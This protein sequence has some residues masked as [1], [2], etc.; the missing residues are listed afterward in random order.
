MR[1]YEAYRT[2][3]C[4]AIGC[5]ESE[6]GSAHLII[7]VCVSLSL[8]WLSFSHLVLLGAKNIEHFFSFHTPTNCS[9]IM[10][11]SMETLASLPIPHTPPA[12]LPS[13]FL[14]HTHH[15][16]SP[17]RNPSPNPNP[18]P[19]P[20]PNPS[21]NPNPYLVPNHRSLFR[22][23][24]PLNSSASS[25]SSNSSYCST[26]SEM[27]AV[28]SMAM[29]RRS[30]TTPEG[31]YDSINTKITRLNHILRNLDDSKGAIIPSASANH[32]LQSA[33]A[34]HPHPSNLFSNGTT[35]LGADTRSVQLGPADYDRHI[36]TNLAPICTRENQNQ[37]HHS[38]RL[39]GSANYDGHTDSSHSTDRAATLHL[40]SGAPK[41][42][43]GRCCHVTMISIP[44]L[45]RP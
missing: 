37:N 2:K 7:C 27:K 26:S 44:I 11:E 8:S 25:P 14:H 40:H 33:P 3:L 38:D 19:S 22:N 9:S 17:P 13:F 32:S 18:N 4:E 28:A 36:C 43:E 34:N 12:E 10:E 39:W 21:P 16:Q 29:R 45:W 20:S 24:S 5:G 23:H 1:T 15:Q 35:N 41:I 6:S 30:S 42:V 31:R